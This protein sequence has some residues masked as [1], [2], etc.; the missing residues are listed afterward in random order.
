MTTLQKA[1]GAI[2]SG[3]A[4]L[5]EIVSYF[6]NNIEKKNR[7]VNAVVEVFQDIDQQIATVEK[8]LKNGEDLPLLGCVATIKDNICYEGKEC[9]AASRILKGYLSPY[10]ATVVKRMIDGGAI[11]IGRT[12]CDEFAMGSSTEN[13]IYGPTRNP[14]DTTRTAGGSSGGAAAA[15]AAAMCNFSLGSDTGGSVRQPASF[16]GVSGYKPTYGVLSRYGLIAF[17]SSM[18]QIGFL[19]NSPKDIID[20]LKVTAGRDPSDAT[21][22]DL[23]EEHGTNIDSITSSVVFLANCI[24]RDGV[25]P[26]IS[27]FFTELKKCL[28]KHGINVIERDFSLIDYVVPVYYII[29]C[30]EASSNL[31]RYDGI[32]YGYCATGAETIEELVTLTRSTGFGREVKRRI[33][34]GTFVLSSGYYDEYY[35]RAQKARRLIATEIA[36]FLKQAPYLILPTTPTTAFVLGSKRDPVSMYMEDIFTVT[37][38]LCGLPAVSVPVHLEGHL[39]F[40]VQIMGRH[41]SDFALLEFAAFLTEIIH[42]I[43]GKQEE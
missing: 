40:G 14:H 23:P 8:R 10:S 28:L 20:V 43:V 38:N 15:L 39:P 11:F 4:T 17:A 41:L 24:W 9:T 22:L 29:A 37:A 30:A 32:K 36:G 42:S 7:E 16:C 19:A 1:K 21:S 18:D 6:L 27:H 35:G 25:Q 26:V 34:L 5:A 12:N 13:T 31:A 33:I 3:E 2:L